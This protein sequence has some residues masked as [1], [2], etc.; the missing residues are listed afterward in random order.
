[1]ELYIYDVDL[2]LKGVID[3]MTSF[4]WIRRYWNAGEFKLLVPYTPINGKL[5][6]KNNLVMKK[7]DRCAAQISYVS[8]RKNLQGLEEIEVQGKFIT[9]WLDKRIL[10]APIVAQDTSQNILYRIANET[11]VRPVITART[12]PK[13]ELEQDPQNHGSEVINYASEQY[14]SAL[15]ASETVSKLG[16]LGFVIETD[17]RAQKHVFRVYQGRN[18]TV[19]QIENPP[20]IFSQDFDNIREQEYTNSVENLKTYA[21]VGGEEKDGVKRQIAEVGFLSG[22]ERDEIFIN[23]SDVTQ[24]YMD[25]EIEQTMP[26]LTYI[27]M[28]KQRGIKDLEQYVE[29]LSFSSKINAHSNLKYKEDFD[30]GDVVTCL[31]K[32]WGIKINVRITEVMESYQNNK[33]EVEVTFGESLPTLFDKINKMR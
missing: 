21:Y 1:M 14:I 16:K 19:D 15:L 26:L 31:D 17:I 29:T 32:R 2:T 23:A 5:L 28:L 24:T 10:L 25:G 9:S 8:I 12:I 20:C 30:L 27:E 18:F 33:Q 13:L 4:I 3:E 6:V 7:G 11:V 22:L